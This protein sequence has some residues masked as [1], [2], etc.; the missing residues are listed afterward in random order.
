MGC[1]TTNSRLP[2]SIP[3]LLIEQQADRGTL[4]NFLEMRRVG[5]IGGEIVP[6]LISLSNTDR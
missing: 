1:L 4:R 5:K 6:D 3:Q 2:R